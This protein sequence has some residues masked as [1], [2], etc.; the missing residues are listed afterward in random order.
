MKPEGYQLQLG[1]SVSIPGP[2]FFSSAKWASGTQSW[3]HTFFK[4]PEQE[5][6]SS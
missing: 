3:L 5:I 6:I 1:K 2:P 4:T